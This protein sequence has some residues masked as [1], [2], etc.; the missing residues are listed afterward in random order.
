MVQERA[1][2]GMLLVGTGANQ[3]ILS[4]F[5]DNMP[6]LVLLD[7]RDPTGR[8][9]C[10]TS[11]G[12]GGV[13]QA[14]RYLLELGHRRIGYFLGEV[15]V[16]PFQDRLHGYISTL[17]DA[18][19]VPDPRL[20]IGGKFEDSDEMREEALIALVSGHDRPTAMLVSNDEYAFF[21][22]RVLR[23]NGLRVP[24][25]ISLIGF[26]DVAFCTHTDPALTT[27]RVDKEGIGKL[28]VR[29]LYAQICANGAELVPAHNQ[30]SVSLVV[31][32]SCRRL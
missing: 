14:V 3:D 4:F 21:V 10:I 23:Q 24:A 16:R 17:F 29:R 13:Q 28:G 25:D 20:V 6:N 31:R 2:A 26:D 32:E 18:G 9:E 11:D 8:L 27:V 5:A 12:F 19:I 1:I 15:D 7:D 30:V 22:M